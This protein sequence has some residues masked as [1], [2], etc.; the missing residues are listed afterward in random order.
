[1]NQLKRFI[2]L[3]N[4]FF[5]IFRLIKKA[6]KDGADYSLVGPSIVKILDKLGPT[7]I[8]FG[9][10]LS[11]R[12]DIIPPDLANELR[13]LLDHGSVVEK[14]YIIKLF[15][16]E[17]NK[18]PKKIFDTFEDSPFAVASLAQVHKATY[19]GKTLAVKIQKPKINDLIEKD[20]KIIKL[21][22]T[23]AYK[24][25]KKL[26]KLEPIINMSLLEFNK[27]LGHELDY[28]LEALN[29]E[30]I[31]KN[32]EG[33]KYFKVPKVE[34]SLSTKKI[35]TAE[36][37]EG[38]SLNEIFDNLPNLAGEKMINYKN[39]KISKKTFIEN[40]INIIFKQ[41]FEDGFFHADPHPGNVIITPAKAIAYIDFGIIGALP[42]RFI[43]TLIEVLSGITQRDVEKIAQALISLDEIKGHNNLAEIENKIRSFLNQWQSGSVMEMTTAEIF[44]ELVKIALES[45]IELPLSLVIVGKTL[46]EY[47]GSLRKI[48]PSLDLINY[49]RPLVEKK[50]GLSSSLEKSLPTSI[51]ELLE[52]IETFP[53]KLQSLIKNLAH[54]GIELTVRFGPIKNNK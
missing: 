17:F 34:L 46:L 16:K 26:K 39:I 10:M 38:I 31:N 11:L 14:K 19:R 53:S 5:A 22:L 52:N 29:M 51:H 20:L 45:K 35:L 33:V 32:F 49:F 48:D 15:K 50:Y 43:K 4:S 27:W 23:I 28:R 21:I 37:I 3:Q 47:D 36:Y 41:I 40:S 13:K 24:I 2:E 7:F 6:K 54:D 1:M 30:R 25:N 42:P 9:Q 44:F 12:P 8:K 18:E